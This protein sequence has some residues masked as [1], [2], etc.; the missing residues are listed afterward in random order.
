M[1]VRCWATSLKQAG[2]PEPIIKSWR[3]LQVAI[4][5]HQKTLTDN[6]IGI[7]VNERERIRVNARRV[8]LQAPM[9]ADEAQASFS[10]I[11]SHAFMNRHTNEQREQLEK[12]E[13]KMNQLD[14]HKKKIEQLA[15]KYTCS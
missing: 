3:G 11:L 5:Q 13:S 12:N 2:L 1:S 15:G 7:Q 4:D 8:G 6:G 9:F 10:N 14:Q